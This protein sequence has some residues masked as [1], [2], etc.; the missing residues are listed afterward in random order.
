MKM[1]VIGI[2]ERKKNKLIMKNI[3]VLGLI[4]CMVSC[5]GEKN[6]IESNL[7]NED[8]FIQRI[9]LLNERIDELKVLKQDLKVDNY[10]D[11][12]KRYGALSEMTSLLKSSVYSRKS[13]NFEK[14][15]SLF[16]EDP[17][18]E[19]DFWKKGIFSTDEGIIFV[20]KLILKIRQ[21]DYCNDFYVFNDLNL[22]IETSKSGELK[23][24]KIGSIVLEPKIEIMGYFI[25][26]KDSVG[27]IEYIKRQNL[28]KSNDI[29]LKQNDDG[30]NRIEGGVLVRRLNHPVFIPFEFEWKD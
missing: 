20:D 8:H 14:W 22:R 19:I 9:E 21:S 28:I 7:D 17:M 15:K 27:N 11:F 26:N 29:L 16:C 3:L 2:L 18:L 13:V 6:T 12:M 25:G 4:I 30:N 5:V 10:Q 1:L 24:G 23:T